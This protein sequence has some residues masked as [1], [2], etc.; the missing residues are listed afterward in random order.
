MAWVA[1]RESKPQWV[2]DRLSECLGPSRRVIR[3]SVAL[4]DPHELA[5]ALLT[6]LTSDA[7]RGSTA[8]GGEPVVALLEG[9][10]ALLP[11]SAE[12]LSQL[13]GPT[14]PTVQLVLVG[15]S[16]TLLRRALAG[17][18]A[19]A[20]ILS[21][22]THADE[23]PVTPHMSLVPPATV[24]LPMSSDAEDDPAPTR[25]VPPWDRNAPGLVVIEEANRPAPVERPEPSDA[26]RPPDRVIELPL[27]RSRPIESP[28]VPSPRTA[29]GSSSGIDAVTTPAVEFAPAKGNTGRWLVGA[30]LVVL[31]CA[32]AI[33]LVFRTQAPVATRPGPSPAILD[34]M[35]SPSASR[36]RT[37][38]GSRAQPS[39]APLSTTDHRNAHPEVSYDPESGSLDV[40]ARDIP[41]FEVL[42]QIAWQTG[43][44]IETEIALDEKVDFEGVDLTPVAALGGL[45]SDYQTISLP[46]TD[47][48]AVAPRTIWVLGRRSGDEVVDDAVKQLLQAADLADGEEAF[49]V[50][51][52][53]GRTAAGHALLD[54]L[55]HADA[56]D[57]EEARHLRDVRGRVKQTLCNLGAG[58]TVGPQAPNLNCD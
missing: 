35:D 54:L 45:L 43:I 30:G 41:L 44:R 51:E 37:F 48:T 23:T 9:C 2:A 25:R 36:P 53:I 6:A 26:E 18:L 32:T 33:W 38:G 3:T 13:S 47:E 19:D 29:R 34:D 49:R 1:P 17:P 10:E 58:F 40:H 20:E 52:R 46:G 8:R 56:R 57:P 15:R 39:R 21:A 14:K 42:I 11:A 24:P 55:A 27:R 5:V 22:P 7:R 12:W 28:P 16:E 50:L 31:T 4:L